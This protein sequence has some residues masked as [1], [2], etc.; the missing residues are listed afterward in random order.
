[1]KK[2]IL[3]LIVPLLFFNSCKNSKDDL[4][5]GTINFTG[6]EQGYSFE[7]DKVYEMSSSWIKEGKRLN[8]IDIGWSDFNLA[9]PKYSTNDIIDFRLHHMGVVDF[10]DLVS[11][12]VDSDDYWTFAYG[13]DDGSHEFIDEVF[14]LKTHKDTYVKL[15]VKNINI[16]RKAI[17]IEYVHQLN[18]TKTFK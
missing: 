13:A 1:M 12:E 14:I 6:D 2:Y 16:K 7:Q 17:E 8:N 4:V 5:F 3:L 10:N 18:G 15:I 9:T 11:F